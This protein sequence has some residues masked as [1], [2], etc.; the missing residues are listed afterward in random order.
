M[1]LPYK[2]SDMNLLILL[3]WTCDG[4]DEVESLW[5]KFDLSSLNKHWKR[6][7]YRVAVTLPKFT[8]HSTI[9]LNK[10]LKNVLK[11]VYFG[12]NSVRVFVIFDFFF[13]VLC[14]ALLAGNGK[15]IRLQSQ[16]R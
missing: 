11:L 14:F 13:L 1:E 16:F 8:I 10:P 5:G 2:D 3:P 6:G 9:D 7:S 12:S 4:L 15:H